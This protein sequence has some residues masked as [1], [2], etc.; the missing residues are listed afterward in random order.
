MSYLDDPRVFFAAERTLLAWQRTAIAIIGLGLIV[1][2]FGLF[3]EN[4]ARGPS[5]RSHMSLAVAVLFLLA[6]AFMAAI[7]TWQYKRFLRDLSAPEV[8]RGHLTWPGPA[9][10]TLL[11]ASSLG[12]ALWFLLS[13]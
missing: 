12:M 13:A 4:G 1:E 3:L 9:L 10:N 6:G 7:S 2:R 8:P 11:A 5:D